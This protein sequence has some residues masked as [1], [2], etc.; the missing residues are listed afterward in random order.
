MPDRILRTPEERF[1]SLPGFAWQPRY[2]E[3]GGL[4]MARIDEGPQD[5]P[6]ALL[7]HGEPSW[8]FL[9][10]TMI[11]P[12]LE[13]GLRVVAPDLI[14]FGRSDKPADARAYTFQAHV[15]WLSGL[16]A[17][18]G[19]ERVILFCQDWGGLLGLRLLAAEPERFERACAANTFLPTGDERPAAAFRLWRAFALWSP[20]FPVGRIVASGVVRKLAPEVRA[21]YDAPFPS[22]EYKAGARAFPR[23]VPVRPDDPASAPNRAA[24]EALRHFDKPFLTLF[25]KHD[26][27]TRGADKVLQ[28][29]IPGAAGQ[30]HELIRGAG[31]F[32]QEDAGPELVEALLRWREETPG[33]P[34]PSPSQIG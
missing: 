6:V 34:A 17:Q 25:G 11:P 10:R 16:V 21:A 24:W 26:P 29:R 5:A 14:G 15:D 1:T 3:V 19:L 18:L 2:L 31:H 33:P 27:I 23:L 32:L 13:A 7:L 30:P 28:R 9:Y 4:R 22:H 8:S 20:V 12:L